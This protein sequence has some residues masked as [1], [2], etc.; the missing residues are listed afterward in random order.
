MQPTTCSK[1]EEKQASL[2][3]TQRANKEKS[4]VQ[5]PIVSINLCVH[6]LHICVVRTYFAIQFYEYG[7]SEIKLSCTKQLF[8]NSFQKLSNLFVAK[9]AQTTTKRSKFWQS[10]KC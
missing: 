2:V 6:E 5:D 7:Y 4:R 9:S 1:V 8:S 3:G 10:T